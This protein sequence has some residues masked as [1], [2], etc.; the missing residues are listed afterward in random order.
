MKKV[1]LFTAIIALGITSCSKGDYTC[2]CTSVYAG[3]TSTT[4]ESYSGINQDNAQKSCESFQ[5]G[6]ETCVL[7]ED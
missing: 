3:V 5:F 2:T 1:L 7:N 4:Q 6:D